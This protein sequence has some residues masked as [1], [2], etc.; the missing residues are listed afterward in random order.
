VSPDHAVNRD[1]GDLRQGEEQQENRDQRGD[2]AGEADQHDLPPDDGVD[3]R[4]QPEPDHHGP[5]QGE[6]PPR[7]KPDGRPSQVRR[8]SSW[9]VDVVTAARIGA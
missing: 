6:D 3:G 4:A 9:F 2:N 7:Q 1:A 5:E 8:R